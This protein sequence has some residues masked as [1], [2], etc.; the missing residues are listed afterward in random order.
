MKEAGR[1]YCA[2][3]GENGIMEY[4]GGLFESYGVE[5]HSNHAFT[6]QSGAEKLLQVFGDVTRH[7]YPDSLKVTNLEDMADY[8]YSL[9]G[10]TGLRQVPRKAMLEVFRE[11]SK[12]GILYVPKDYGM[13]VAWGKTCVPK[14]A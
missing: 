13:F 5:A 1:F 14:Q 9:T 11:N 3:Y 4:I 2:T 8:V 6:M 7:S 10:M 12:D